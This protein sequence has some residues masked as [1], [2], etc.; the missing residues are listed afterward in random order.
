M[1]F[2][3]HRLPHELCR[4]RVSYPKTLIWRRHPLVHLSWFLQEF[5]I[6]QVFQDGAKLDSTILKFSSCIVSTILKFW[7]FSNFFKFKLKIKDWSQHDY[8]S[9]FL[10]FQDFKMKQNLIL[11][12]LNYSRFFSSWRSA[13]QQRKDKQKCHDLRGKSKFSGRLQFDQLLCRAGLK[14]IEI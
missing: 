2:L 8:F 12:D 6:F 1:M 7:V 4:S 11:Q 14:G 5:Y 3:S 10:F 13:N 9:S